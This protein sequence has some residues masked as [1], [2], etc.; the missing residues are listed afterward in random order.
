MG[1]KIA[2]GPRQGAAAG[3]EWRRY[4]ATSSA[5]IALGPADYGI[6]DPSE[7]PPAG[8]AQATR[9]GSRP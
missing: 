8:G 7:P 1:E 3:E 6:V 2:A 9:G 4:S 5:E